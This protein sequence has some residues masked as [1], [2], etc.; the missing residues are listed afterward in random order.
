MEGQPLSAAT[1]TCARSSPIFQPVPSDVARPVALVSLT[2]THSVVARATLVFTDARCPKCRRLV[3]A[4]PGLPTIEVRTVASNSD[5]SGR[6]R[7]VDCRRCSTL[8]EVIEHAR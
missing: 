8:L 7:V 6:G 5:R 1:L 4:I 3:M 2:V